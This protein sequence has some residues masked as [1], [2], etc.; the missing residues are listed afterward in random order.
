MHQ[1][2][3]TQQKVGLASAMAVVLLA[4]ILVVT[5]A[6]KLFHKKVFQQSEDEDFNAAV[7]REKKLA[8]L[9]AKKEGR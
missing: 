8:K 6:Q 7:K 1:I 4:I 9:A 2:A 5:V 3:H